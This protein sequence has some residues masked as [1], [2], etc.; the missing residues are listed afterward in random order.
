M[1]YCKRGHPWNEENT[2]YQKHK[3]GRVQRYCYPCKIEAARA[4][5]LKMKQEIMDYYGGCCACCGETILDFLALDHLNNDGAAH[6]KAE[7]LQTG[8]RTYYWIKRNN[9]P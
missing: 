2:R 8:W 3:N 6:R 7:Q 1:E 4:Q 5:H 9:F